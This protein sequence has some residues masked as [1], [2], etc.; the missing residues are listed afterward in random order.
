M[1]VEQNVS[2]KPFNTFGLG[3][4]AHHFLRITDLGTLQET[5][6]C[7]IFSEY[8]LLSGG[9][10]VLLTRPVEELVLFM[11]AQGREILQEDEKSITIRVMCGENWHDLVMWTLKKGFGGLENLALIPGRTGTAPVQNIGAYGVELKDNLIGLEAVEISSGE[12]VYFDADTCKLGYRDS[13]FKKEMRG[14]YVIWSVDL[15]L[16]KA[17][18]ILKTD[19]GDIR[20]KLA[21]AGIDKPQPLDVANAVIS[22]RQQKLPDPA[23]LGNSGSFFKN[24]VISSKEFQSLKNKFPEIP[25][26]PQHSDT[27][28][29]PAGWLIE[30]LG[31]KGYRKGDAGVHQNQSLVLVNYGKATGTEI[32]ELAQEIQGA[33]WNYF[34]I[35]IEP[36][37]N[38]Y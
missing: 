7:G 29:I 14:K 5:L 17:G 37:V 13:I 15:K 6:R 25:G 2:L 4:K 18:H 20:T 26:Y 9:S 24:P 35:N 30:K 33:V 22:I 10:N 27:V 1:R 32:L 28:K 31:Y 21:E 38:I 16:S 19:Y 23:K 11:D 34:S 36:E 3:V 8:F 12:L